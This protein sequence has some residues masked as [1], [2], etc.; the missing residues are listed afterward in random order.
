MLLESIFPQLPNSGAELFLFISGALG[1]VLVVYSQFVEA[2]HRRD[3]IRILGAMGLLAYSLFIWNILF[4]IVS[5]G[6]GIAALVEFIEIYSGY[7][8]HTP[9][10]IKEYIKKYKKKR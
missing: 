6:I 7:H 10:E 1:A 9:H 5:V 2:E 4:I 8:K 3:L